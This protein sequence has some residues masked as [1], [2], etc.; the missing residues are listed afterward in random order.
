MHST[1][2]CFG[3]NRPFV[4]GYAE[5]VRPLTC[6][7]KKDVPFKW[8]PECTEAVQ[9]LKKAITAKPVLRRPDHNKPF[10]MEVDASQYVL[11]AILSQKDKQGKLRPVGYYSKTLIPA[12]CNYDV[13]DR[14][15]LALVRALQHW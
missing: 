1:L 15:L 6:L 5:I 10:T 12:E 3:Y 14:E 9:K 4:K 2:G 11:G 13:Y 8:T 7:T